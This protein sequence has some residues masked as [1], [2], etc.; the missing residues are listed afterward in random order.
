MARGRNVK[1][2]KAS[3]EQLEQPTPEYLAHGGFHRQFVTHVDSQTK[4]MVYVAA[5]DPVER[6]ERAG[7]LSYTQMAAIGFMRLLWDRA[8]ISQR[9]T[10][11]Y[12]ERIPGGGN[13]ERRAAIEID[14]RK[15][16][17]RVQDYIP[18]TYYDVFENV[19]RHGE[20]AG[21][22]GSR[23]GFGDRSGADRAHT[24]VCFVA[25]VIAMKERL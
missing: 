19:V 9:V 4:A 10:A 5:H 15:D 13:E 20:Q 2:R 18:K 21:V 3:M 22:A 16:L 14:A 8:G 17:H 1:I 7:R 25:D 6:W 12:G 24:I 11:S 23:L